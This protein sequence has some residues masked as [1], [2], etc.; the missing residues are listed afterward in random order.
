[1]K[2]QDEYRDPQAAKKLLGV[3]A[4]PPDPQLNPVHVAAMA[5]VCLAIFNL[6]ETITRK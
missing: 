6:S 4:S 3:G 5:D 1:M 2:F